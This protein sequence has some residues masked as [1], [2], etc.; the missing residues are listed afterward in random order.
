MSRAVRV[1]MVPDGTAGGGTGVTA[2]PAETVV[3]RGTVVET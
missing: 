2:V 1:G 3:W